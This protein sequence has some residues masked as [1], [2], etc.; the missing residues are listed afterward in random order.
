M[1]V[2]LAFASAGAGD[3]TAAARLDGIPSGVTL[4]PPV[5]NECPD[6]RH[7]LRNEEDPNLRML[8]PL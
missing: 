1:A 2:P 5:T 6:A 8:G 4:R 7:R 3:L